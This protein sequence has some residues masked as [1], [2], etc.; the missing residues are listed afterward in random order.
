MIRLKFIFLVIIYTEL[1]LPR[2]FLISNSNSSLT[3]IAVSFFSNTPSILYSNETSFIDSLEVITEHD[4]V[5]WEKETPFTVLEKNFISN[6]NISGGSLALFGKDIYDDSNFFIENFGGT[7]LRNNISST[8]INQLDTFNLL[9]NSQTI[10]IQQVDLNSNVLLKYNEYEIASI[11]NFTS[12][13]ILNGFFIEEVSSNDLERFIM[14][15]EQKLVK[16]KVLLKVGNTGFDGLS[17]IDVPIELDN[18]QNIKSISFILNIENDYLSEF[19]LIPT[20]RSLGMQ[21]QLIDLPFGNL[22][23]IAEFNSEYISSGDGAIAYID[24]MPNSNAVGK[25]SLK[26]M[27]S[28]IIDSSEN[29]LTV[30]HDNGEVNFESEVPLLYFSDNNLVQMSEYSNIELNLKNDMPISGFQLCFEFDSD[31]ILFIEGLQSDRIPSDWWVGQFGL[32]SNDDIQIASLGFSNIPPGDGPILNIEILSVGEVYGSSQVGICDVY[33][34][35]ENSESIENQFSNTD[36]L[37]FH[38]DIFITPHIIKSPNYV[39]IILSY[40]AEDSFSG[41]QLDLLNIDEP[42]EEL[43]VYF[44]SYITGNFINGTTSRILG[45]IDSEVGYYPENGNLFIASFNYLN[46]LENYVEFDN[47]MFSDNQGEIKYSEIQPLN[48]NESLNGDVD[49]S[50][51]LDIKDLLILKEYLNS[52]LVLG[53]AQKENADIDFDGNI[54]ITDIIVLIQM[55]LR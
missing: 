10:E 36:I 22:N 32:G 48:I 44:E 20:Q 43:L 7:F 28:T 3:E 11:Q 15:I 27:E 53:L 12:N 51:I 14:Y 38:P 25:I 54:T 6:F 49:S 5:F 50:G 34:F 23:I 9:L 18:E 41:F 37:I 47:L 21:W 55:A 45:F 17:S 1:C 33:L 8:L 52:N 31:N 30:I 29:Q 39:D 13:F 16:D 46:S 2:T 26:I 40:N 19:N 4:L 35:N 42:I 24:A